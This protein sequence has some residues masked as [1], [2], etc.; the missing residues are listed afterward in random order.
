MNTFFLPKTVKA[1]IKGRAK[2]FR[3]RYNQLVHGYGRREL[4]VGLRQL[5]LRDRD[6]VMVHSSLDQFEGF[7][8]RVTDII[9]S[10]QAVVGSEGTILMPTIPF[11]GTALEYVQRAKVFDVAKTPSQMGMITEIFRRIPGVVRSVHPT[12]SV[13]AWGACAGEMVR[14]HH[15]AKTPCG[16]NSPFARL[17]PVS[18]K[19]L[20]WGVGIEAMTFFHA[21]EEELEPIMPFSP[22]TKELFHLTSIGH[23][24]EVR[25]TTTRLFEAEISRRRNLSRLMSALQQ[26]GCWHELYVK[27]L[28]CIL[29]DACE[30][31]QVCWAMAREGRFCYD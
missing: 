18:G 5:G 11:V 1:T 27:R 22:F 28:R 26:R 25:H 14:D 16:M 24:G 3:K 12:H 10:L 29:L 21:L 17:K 9:A 13:A 4:E 30:V 19:I 8:G 7:D 2:S 23:A 15:A 31:S 20:L 6:I